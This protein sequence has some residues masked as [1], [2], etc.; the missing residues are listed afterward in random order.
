MLQVRT[1][2]KQVLYLRIFISITCV[3]YI[4]PGNRMS[5]ILTNS[6]CRFKSLAVKRHM[7]YFPYQV[8][9]FTIVCS[10]LCTGAHYTVH[11]AQCTPFLS[12]VPSLLYLLYR[13]TLT[14]QASRPPSTY[15]FKTCRNNSQFI[16]HRSPFF[17]SFSYI[18]INTN[19]KIYLNAF[20][21]IHIA[22]KTEL[23]LARIK[24]N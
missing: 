9:I 2:K 8:Y 6:R 13:G 22:L 3:Q 17:I 7:W 19:I 15:T 24:I 10:T 20:L 23:C 5:I 1:N 4:H 16:I 12:P 11:S 21:T 14:V 18:I